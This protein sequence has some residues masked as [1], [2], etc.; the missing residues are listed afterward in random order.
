MASTP[1]EAKR[2]EV[3]KEGLFMWLGWSSP[4]SAAR[5]AVNRAA[6]TGSA[7]ISVGVW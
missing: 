4:S 3:E 1:R 6:G 5:E 7:G 2:V